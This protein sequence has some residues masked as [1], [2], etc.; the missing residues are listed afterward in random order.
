MQAKKGLYATEKLWTGRPFSSAVSSMKT[1]LENFCA[2]G[3]I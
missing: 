2:R 3:R 1:M